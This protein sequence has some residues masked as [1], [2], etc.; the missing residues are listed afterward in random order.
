[1]WDVGDGIKQLQVNA[2]DVSKMAM[3]NITY[4]WPGGL[5]VSALYP[6]FHEAFVVCVEE[7]K[8]KRWY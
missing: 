5:V 2:K 4:R 8:W 6:D 7:G 3:L 1:M